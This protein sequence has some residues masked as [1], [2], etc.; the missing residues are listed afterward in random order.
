M[1]LFLPKVLCAHAATAATTSRPKPC[2]CAL[3]FIQRPSSG[4]SVSHSSSAAMPRHSLLSHR[5]MTKE[6][7]FGSGACSRSSHRAMYSL[8]D[9]GSH[10]MNLAI[11][12]V[13]HAKTSS[14]S[15]I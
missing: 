10:R 7:V 5:L 12:G 2:P 6:N 1:K 11:E 4:D 14:A 8:Q 13:M 9:G 3:S 15:V